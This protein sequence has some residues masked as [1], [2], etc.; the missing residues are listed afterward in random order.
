MQ[1]KLISWQSIAQNVAQAMLTGFCLRHGASGDARI[2][3][4]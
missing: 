4:I 3:G 1:Y 2:A